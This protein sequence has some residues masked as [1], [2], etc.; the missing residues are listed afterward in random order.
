MLQ[1]PRLNET[2]L[3]RASSSLLRALRGILKS[4]DDIAQSRGAAE[5]KIAAYED[6]LGNYSLVVASLDLYVEIRSS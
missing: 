2:A 5:A 4:L 6:W 3:L 1:C